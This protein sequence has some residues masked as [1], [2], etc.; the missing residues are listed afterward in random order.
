MTP[1]PKKG[2]GTVNAARQKLLSAKIIP[3]PTKING[4]QWP[5]GE[6]EIARLWEE[7]R[8]TRSEKDLIVFARHVTG[9]VARAMAP[10]EPSLLVLVE[11][12]LRKIGG[13]L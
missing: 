11:A 13:S 9:M 1:P 4:S 3:F 7:F 2:G 12:A 8:R 5:T 10:D 6:T